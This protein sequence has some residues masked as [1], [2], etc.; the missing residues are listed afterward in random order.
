MRI[1]QRRKP[2][3]QALQLARD[4]ADARPE[5]DL[6]Q[7][8]S[9][10]YTPHGLAREVDAAVDA[11]AARSQG[12]HRSVELRQHIA[13]QTRPRGGFLGRMRAHL[14]R[15]RQT[16]IARPMPECRIYRMRW[17]GPVKNRFTAVVAS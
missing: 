13:A 6:G 1:S 8:Q 14:C 12:G 5:L 2:V 7:Q 4:Q 11:A 16:A 17:A 15:I 10:A 3:I 9:R